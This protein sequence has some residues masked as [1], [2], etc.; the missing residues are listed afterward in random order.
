[1]NID[2]LENGLSSFT[3]VGN[4]C[5]TELVTEN[6]LRFDSSSE[7]YSATELVLKLGYK[8]RKM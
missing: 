4:F 3:K 8:E 2:C 6:G 7:F 5:I 1:M